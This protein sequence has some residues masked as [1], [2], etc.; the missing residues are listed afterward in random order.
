MKIHEKHI[1]AACWLLFLILISII[2]LLSSC[3]ITYRPETEI[4]SCQNDC[5][6][7][8]TRLIDSLIVSHI[9]EIECLQDTVDLSV[10]EFKLDSALKVNISMLQSLQDSLLKGV[11]GLIRQDT[12]YI[13]DTVMYADVMFG[14]WM[15]H[16]YLMLSEKKETLV[17]DDTIRVAI[18]IINYDRSLADTF[19]L[20]TDIILNGGELFEVRI[21]TL[22]GMFNHAETRWVVN[23]VSIPDTLSEIYTVGTLYDMQGKIIDELVVV[24]DDPK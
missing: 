12:L 16:P 2:L 18:K 24:N 6:A 19:R 11:D 10:V 4:M 7:T 14:R 1:Q 8:D 13:H 23:E 15:E 9:A 20:V 3:D 21:D 5:T 22:Y 17:N